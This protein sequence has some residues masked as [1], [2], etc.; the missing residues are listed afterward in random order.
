MLPSIGS[1]GMLL[2]EPH[3]WQHSRASRRAVPRPRTIRT[4]IIMFTG[5]AETP[6]ETD[7]RTSN[8]SPP[9]RIAN[10]THRGLNHPYVHK[11]KDII[12]EAEQSE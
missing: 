7:I 3:S 9:I 1:L 4:P 11:E 6:R 5:S 2:L 8:K 12:Y 10:A